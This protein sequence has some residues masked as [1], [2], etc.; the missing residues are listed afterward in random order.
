[1]GT[2]SPVKTKPGHF[3]AERD[4]GSVLTHAFKFNDGVEKVNK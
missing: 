2:R 4:P 1:V 3:A